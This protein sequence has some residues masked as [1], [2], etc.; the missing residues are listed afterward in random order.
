MKATIGRNRQGGDDKPRGFNRRG[1]RIGRNDRRPA[2]HPGQSP[3]GGQH[4]RL[5]PFSLHG[6]KLCRYAGWHPWYEPKPTSLAAGIPGTSACRALHG[7]AKQRCRQDK[8]QR[9]PLQIQRFVDRF[10]TMQEERESADYD[11]AGTF[12]QLA[13][14]GDIN[15]SEDAITQ[16]RQAPEQDRRSFAVYVLLNLRNT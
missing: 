2:A 7:T 12:E 9:F 6:G 14:I 1:Q 10:V 11:P 15:L 5:R 4:H 16:F 8:I 13:V 3:P